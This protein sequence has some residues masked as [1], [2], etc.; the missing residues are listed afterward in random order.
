MYQT[1]PKAQDSLWRGG[2]GGGGE[3]FDFPRLHF[4]RFEGGMIKKTGSQKRNVDIS[5]NVW[6]WKLIFFGK[7]TTLCMYLKKNKNENGNGA[8]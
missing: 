4:V 5:Q 1:R 2:W 3:K 6:T 8:I 7:K